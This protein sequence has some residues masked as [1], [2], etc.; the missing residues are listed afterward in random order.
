MVS[1]P[2]EV[3]LNH[4]PR[5]TLLRSLQTQD[6]ELTKAFSLRKLPPSTD[7]FFFWH[8]DRPRMA[9]FAQATSGT[10]DLHEL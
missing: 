7:N 8:Y 4:Y 10:A 9:H 1:L 6:P 2:R 3:I 5:S